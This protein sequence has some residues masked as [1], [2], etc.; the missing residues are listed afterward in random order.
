MSFKEKFKNEINNLKEN[1][2]KNLI[3]SL[4]FATVVLFL[5]CYFGSYSFFE[6][7]FPNLENVEFY[8]I[9]YHNLMAF[10]LFF[11]LGTLF[12]KFVMKQKLSEFG[13]GLKNKKFFLIAGAISLV[14]FPLL[15]MS[16]VLDP[17]M[18]STYPL[19]DF[20]VYGQ[21]YNILLY[22]VSYLLYYVGWEF[23]F[24]GILFFGSKE[25]CGV[26]GAILLTTL[27]SAL[28]HTS[29]AGFGK[30]MIETLSAIPAGLI[31]GYFAHK[32]DSI[33]LS[34]LCHVLIGFFT[35]I[36]IFVLI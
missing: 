19:V 36:F 10:V 26:L 20:V 33:Y 30:P 11:G 29:I 7:V 3:L 24:R 6:K 32:T 27:I 2:N 16:T 25:K 8:K 17:E 9:I 18:V 31:F 34:L 28:I 12:V 5:Y 15:G 14:V 4:V 22:F 23:L 1:S 13:L 35:D 21:W